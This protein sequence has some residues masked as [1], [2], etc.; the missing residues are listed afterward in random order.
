[1]AGRSDSFLPIPPRVSRAR[2]AL[3][4]APV[5]SADC[6]ASDSSCHSKCAK[7]CTWYRFTAAPGCPA[8]AVRTSSLRRAGAVCSELL[9]VR[10]EGYRGAR[11]VRLSVHGCVGRGHLRNRAYASRPH[12]DPIYRIYASVQTFRTPN[13][14]CYWKP[15]SLGGRGF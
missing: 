15:A 6:C 3:S 11:R 12:R 5:D 4:R 13:A 7:T 8:V 2:V 9:V 1:M 14:A 10:A